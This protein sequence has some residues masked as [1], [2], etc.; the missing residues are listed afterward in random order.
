M[1]LD[2]LLPV[3]S[4]LRTGKT[5]RL[6]T[7]ARGYMGWSL[8]CRKLFLHP[9]LQPKHS[10]QLPGLLRF[11]TV[12][13]LPTTLVDPSRPSLF[14]HLLE[15]PTPIS[16]DLPAYAVS[17]LDRPPR[18]AQ[19]PAVMGWLPAAVSSE[20]GEEAGLRDFTENPK[21]LDVLH[22]VIQKAI[23]DGKDERLSAEAMQLGKGWMHVND[24][25]NLPE[26]G[27]IS[28]PDDIIASVRVEG[29]EILPKTYN[30]MPTYRICTTDGLTTLSKGLEQ[31][32]LEAL[33]RIENY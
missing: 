5:W 12:S 14:Y 27:R 24:D 6:H 26:M 16:T 31:R 25:R 22:Q 30:P 18:E 20:G 23:E 10:S 15:A 32:L 7:C 19:S 17:M 13:S 3:K 8:R 2:H 29:G 9:S 11:R 4:F 21:F 33:R 28:R 1:N